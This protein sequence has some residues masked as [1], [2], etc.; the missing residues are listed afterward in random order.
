MVSSGLY[1]IVCLYGFASER[2]YRFHVYETHDHSQHTDFHCCDCNRSFKNGQSFDLHNKTCSE[3]PRDVLY[4]EPCNIG[5]RSRGKLLE[6]LLSQNHKPI[7]CLGSKKCKRKFRLFSHMV[8]HLE[9]G[10]CRSKMDRRIVYN[11]VQKYDTSGKLTITSS[12]P[13]IQP[14]MLTGF[15]PATLREVLKASPISEI[16]YDD[17]DIGSETDNP[18]LTPTT[19]ATF[20]RRDSFT[21]EYSSGGVVLT[22]TSPG[23]SY[24]GS[25][26]STPT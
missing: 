21:S 16:D 22:P 1:C 26:A 18:I 19:S 6:H 5:F 24:F 10:A 9:S 23:F 7:K 17:D 11:L 14:P 2:D 13:P 12:A 15:C 20:S 4:C 25:F 3:I 8:Q